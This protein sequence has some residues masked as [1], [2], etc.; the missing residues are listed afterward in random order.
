MTSSDP[1]PIRRS[2][3][4]AY[5]EVI[6]FAIMM[7]LT[8]AFMVPY[9]LA[10]GAT[11]FQSGLLTSVRNLVL[12]LAQLKSA[13]GVHW[14]GSRKKL[15]LWTAGI[16][17]AL[18]IPTAFVAPLFG[19]WAVGAL[20]VLYT[21]G[22]TSNA[23][24]TPAWG[25]IVSEYLRP[26]DRGK[27]FGKRSLLLGIG[28]AA[29]GLLAGGVLQLL[30]GRALLGFALLCLAAGAS[31][32][33]SWFVLRKLEELPWEEPREERLTF[34]RFLRRS[35]SD[36]FGRFTLC[37]TA[38]SFGTFFSS[39]YVAVY[40]LED[41]KYDYFTYS[42]VVLAGNLL[43]NLMLPRWGSIGDRHGNWVVV[44]WTFLG[45][46][47]I[48]F[49]WALPGHPAWLLFLFLLGGFLWGGLNLCSVNFVYD[50]AAPSARARLL[51]YFNVVNGLGIS[52]GT[53][54]GGLALDH[55]PRLFEGRDV[56]IA[57]FI[58]SGILRLTAAWLFPLFVKEVRTADPVGLR[59]ITFD[60][61]GFRAVQVL[62]WGANRGIEARRVFKERRRAPR[63][64]G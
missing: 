21:L 60:L 30:A 53:L 32:A 19:P 46:A 64:R 48:P 6:P 7:G 49:L 34:A 44:K 11:A 18:W 43:G 12:S 3:R 28:V 1:E 40:M 10:L 14:A 57:L 13:E 39:P 15:I 47:V 2:L 59:R 24:G 50:A 36:N 27:F 4:L 62:R 55:L 25:S 54:A 35:T 41:L 56:W 5:Y 23:F 42:F 31:R 51:G 63:D 26:E 9:A 45:V 58:G 61:V 33:V 16:Q 8:E 38:M 22:T 37:M 52:A 29:A 17:A 20:V